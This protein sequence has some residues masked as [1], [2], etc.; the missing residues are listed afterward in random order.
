[1]ATLDGRALT[2]RETELVRWMLIHGEVGAEHFLDRV[3]SLRVVASCSCGCASVDFER[4]M[5]GEKVVV[6]D[7]GVVGPDG[8]PGG[9][10]LFTRDGRLAG[11]EVYSHGDPIADLPHPSSLERLPAE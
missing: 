9:V 10:F 8:M 11:L 6:S 1:M 4:N 3:D 2:P 7:F 5:H